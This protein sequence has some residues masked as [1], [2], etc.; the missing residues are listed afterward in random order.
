MTTYEQPTL[1]DTGPQVRL[2]D[3]QVSRTAVEKAGKGVGRSK[4]RMLCAFLIVDDLAPTEAAELAMKRGLGVEA[5]NLDSH[6]RR[7]QDLAADG[8]LEATGEERGGI[9]Y[10]LTEKGRSA[11]NRVWPGVLAAVREDR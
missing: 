4:A 10:R 5:R 2:T 1:G 6:R 8:Y 9:V 3:P 11:A 7:V